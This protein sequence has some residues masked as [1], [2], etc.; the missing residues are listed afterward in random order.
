MK[1]WKKDLFLEGE[2]NSISWEASFFC[3]LIAQIWFSIGL[4]I[5]AYVDSGCPK[6]TKYY[7]ETCRY[8]VENQKKL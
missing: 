5:N 8:D 1:G 4:I 7:K 6:G 2:S 3:K